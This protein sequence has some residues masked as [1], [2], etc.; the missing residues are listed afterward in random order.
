VTRYNL[1]YGTTRIPMVEVL[2]AQRDALRP[3][4]E[5]DIVKRVYGFTMHHAYRRALRWA[6][7]NGDPR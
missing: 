1:R 6:R 2:D 7:K 3:I 4:S 5:R